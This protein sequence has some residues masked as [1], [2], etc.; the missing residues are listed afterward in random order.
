MRRPAMPESSPKAS[1]TVLPKKIGRVL[2]LVLGVIVLS[3]IYFLSSSPSSSDTFI[4]P[5][6]STTYNNGEVELKTNYTPHFY[7]GFWASLLGTYKQAVT[8]VWDRIESPKMPTGSEDQIVDGIYS[9]RFNPSAPYLISGDQ[10]DDFYLRNLSI[11]YQDLLDP[12]TAVSAMDMHNR[13]RIDV[14]SLAYGLAAL[15]QL[16]H[17]I[18]TLSPITPH[19]VLAFNV[20]SYPSD[21][22]FSLFQALTKLKATPDTSAIANSLEQK[23]HSGLAVSYSNYLATVRD[24]R[25]GLIKTTLHLSGARDAAQRTSSFYDNVIL[26]KTEQLATQLGFDHVQNSALSSLRQTILKKYWDSSQGHFIDDIAPGDEHSYSSDWLIAL[27]TGFLDPAN[28]SDLAKL[29]QISNY[30]DSR[31]L[32]DPLPIRY[33]AAPV[34]HENIFVKLFVNSY[35]ST[36]IWSYWGDLY[37]NLETDLY[38]ETHDSRYAAKVNASLSKWNGVVVKDRGYPETLDNNGNLLE[39]AVYESIRRNGWVVDLKSV[40]NAWSKTRSNPSSVDQPVLYN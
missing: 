24:S 17:P 39:T 32:T 5:A 37:I 38:A 8:I 11:F 23:Y 15:Q 3:F 7:S 35:G 29:E 22:M 13:E 14:Q 28:S 4:Q 12:S 9:L 16:H 6:F 1:S 27:P 25:S 33:T 30:I 31:H 34:P 18:T 21:T 19:G 20:Y 40:A 2:L 36:A 10:F 26:W